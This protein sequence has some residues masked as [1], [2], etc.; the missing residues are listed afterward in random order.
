MRPVTTSTSRSTADSTPHTVAGAVS[1]GANVIVAG[2][3]LYRDPDGL[4][5]AV[6]ELRA[7]RPS[8]LAADGAARPVAMARACAIAA[9]RSSI[10][11]STAP[12]RPQNTSTA[13]LTGLR[14][15]SPTASA[16]APACDPIAGRDCCRFRRR[17]R[18]VGLVVDDHE[19]AAVVFEQQVDVA[20]DDRA[21]PAGLV[22]GRGH[23]QLTPSL[24]G[25]NGAGGTD[26][27]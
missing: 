23:V 3:A 19:L 17:R 15:T 21:G 9:G 1:S 12:S 27:R 14:N 8:Q 4:E 22:N 18:P 16:Y 13:R 20:L 6:T 10:S 25:G 11:C 7:P 5:H 2:S 26:H 24:V